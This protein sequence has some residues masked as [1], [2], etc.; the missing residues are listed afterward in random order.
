MRLVQGLQ[1]LH[2]HGGGNTF[3]LNDVVY[4]ITDLTNFTGRPLPL[5]RTAVS[6]ST[7]RRFTRHCLQEGV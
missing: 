3:A 2:A 1:Q 7:N 5:H 4:P 6:E